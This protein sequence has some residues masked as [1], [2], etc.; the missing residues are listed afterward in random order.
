MNRSE[1]PITY[2]TILY[3]TIESK[4]PNQTMW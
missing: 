3:Y 4:H 1:V 2:Y